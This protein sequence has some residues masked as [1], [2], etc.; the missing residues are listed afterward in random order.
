M[1]KFYDT[2]ESAL[3]NQ[4][5]AAESIYFCRDTGNLYFD[6]IIENAR[7]QIRDIIVLGTESSRTSML[8]PIPNKLY[9]VIESGSM[10]IY[11][12]GE[13][14]KLGVGQQLHFNNICVENGSH[15]ITDSRISAS[16][17]AQF[18]PDLSVED[19]V[20]DINVVCSEGKAVITCT[21]DY[22]IY[23]N[24]IIN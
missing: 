1:F 12:N 13:W 11:Y 18:T 21:S 23:G 6:S 22:K 16:D 4:P 5:F 20:S 3:A 10:Y 7:V 2:P 15:T 19:L 14:K 8:A 9:C 24:L 17:T